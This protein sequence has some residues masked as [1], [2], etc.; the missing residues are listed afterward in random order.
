MR[1]SNTVADRINVDIEGLRDRIDQ[2]HSE[3]PLWEKLSMA[4][5]LR[6]LLEEAL[7][8]AETPKK[9]K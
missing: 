5:K 7:E 9:S 3:N 4:Q 2:A 6:Q 1:T 8:K